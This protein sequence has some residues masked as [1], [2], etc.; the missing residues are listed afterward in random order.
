MKPLHR[1]LLPLTTLL[2]GWAPGAIAQAGTP[3]FAPLPTR[4]DTATAFYGKTAI[5][6]G[7]TCW[8]SVGSEHRQVYVWLGADGSPPTVDSLFS[9]ARTLRTLREVRVVGDTVIM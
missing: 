9:D 5:G 4:L 1:S 6:R 8:S 7:I 2:L 3:T